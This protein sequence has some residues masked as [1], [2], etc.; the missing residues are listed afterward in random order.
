MQHVMK[1]V[2]ARDILKS[3]LF[4]RRDSLNQIIIVG[5]LSA[6]ITACLFTGSS[7]K[8]SLK[9]GSLERLG[10][11]NLMISSGERFFYPSLAARVSA[12]SGDSCSPLL[13][14]DGYCQNFLTGATT[15]NTKI[16]AV[17]SGFFRFQG[18]DS[19]GISR[20]KVGINQNLAR[21]LGVKPGDDIIIH[22]TRPDPLPPG[23][24]FS[25]SGTPG[26]SRVMKVEM[27]I[28]SSKCGNFSLGISQIRP[29]NIFMNLADLT[30]KA[31]NHDVPVNR[32]LI[33]ISNRQDEDTLFTVLSEVLTPRDLGLKVRISEKT[34]ETELVSDRIFIDSS[35]VSSVLKVIPSG[36]PLITYLANSI[37]R[38]GRSTPYSFITALP[39]T[40]LKESNSKG[41]VIDKW[42]S[43]DL[44]AHNGDTVDLTWY[45]PAPGHNLEEE[46]GR[47]II[48][49]IIDNGNKICDPSLMPDFPG[50]SETASCRSWDPGVPLDLDRIRDK[51]EAYWNK[52]K[53]TPKAF[54]TYS[55]GKLLWSSNFGTA[56]AIRFPAGIRPDSLIARL[57]GTFNP[58][59]TGFTITDMKAKAVKAADESVDFSSLFLSLGIFILISCIILL[60]LTVS[61]FLETRRT[62]VKTYYSL[63][64]KNRS[65]RK[66]LFSET[67]LLSASGALPG[68]F[69]GYL[70][71]G[72]IIRALNTVWQGAVQINTLQPEFSS[73]PFMTGFLSAI[74]ITV[75]LFLIRVRHFLKE[76]NE[77]VTGRYKVPRARIN[78]I[79]LVI[80]G[81]V[82]VTLLLMSVIKQDSQI[83]VSF[84]GGMFLFL[85]FILLLRQY[86]L[87]SSKP[88]AQS[89]SAGFNSFRKYYS[90][91][92]S[93]AL[94]PVIFIAAGIFAVIITGANRQEINKKMLLPPGGT[95]GYQLWAETAIPVKNSLITRQGR[96]EFGLNE[97]SLKYLDFTEIR[98]Y[99]G[100]DASCLN[101]NHVSSP[102]LLGVDPASFIKNGSL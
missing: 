100:D 95:G 10:N 16:L 91:H 65:I 26:Y 84:S 24:P 51:D 81:I 43:D 88:S 70:I 56:S 2:I 42:L 36:Y 35:I 57:T 83:T 50:I 25:A 33:Q 29:L 28:P 39:S 30:N 1:S 82:T 86:Y 78:L 48:T 75:I 76:L 92:P 12:R 58:S 8:Y 60:S 17:S 20:G 90:F 7:V 52:Y 71:N 13:E 73:G 94:M 63:G 66:I 4:Y 14:T 5:L 19:L 61:L 11:T 59:N 21:H 27:I 89:G 15:L 87:G 18:Y 99:S 72:L 69:A 40:I 9:A 44:S 46:T 98:R 53:G 31:N 6:V 74:I 45:K 68:A 79:M 97:D 37:S 85:T 67:I 55:E 80:S 22:Y 62:R 49:G 34:G 32:L 41:I 23:A 102:P 64:Y 54:I 93:Q 3:V 38:N 47:F 101:L 77:A 96:E